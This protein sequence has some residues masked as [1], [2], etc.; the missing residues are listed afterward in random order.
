MITQTSLAYFNNLI[1]ET[2]RLLAGI[3]VF[4][5][6]PQQTD[7]CVE[8]LAHLRRQRDSIREIDFV[9]EDKETA[10]QKAHMLAHMQT[11][12]DTVYVFCAQMASRYFDGMIQTEFFVTRVL[13]ETPPS[14]RLIKEVEFVTHETNG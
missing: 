4:G 6:T 2:N 3:E 11:E 9:E 5:G 7:M 12:D 10:V 8:Q 13:P 1:A 14:V